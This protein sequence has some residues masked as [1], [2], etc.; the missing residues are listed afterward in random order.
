MSAE[1]INQPPVPERSES[2]KAGFE[3]YLSPYTYRYGS[4]EMKRIWS[5][6]DYWLTSRDIWVAV[7]QIQNKAGLVSDK[8]LEDLK[9]HRYDLSVERILQLEREKGHDVGGAI[10]EF[11]EA[12]PIGG[13]IVH[14]GLTSEDILSNIEIIQIKESFQIIRERLISTLDAFG[15][16]INENKYLVCMGW[17]H[18]Q[19]AEPT[20]Y[21]YRFAKYA[22]DLLSDLKLLDLANPM[23]K[24]KGIKGAVGTS[25]SFEELLKDTQMSADKHEEM[26]MGKLDIEAASIT[27]QTYPRKNLF[28]TETILASIGQSLH[29]FAFDIQLLQSSAIDEVSE[30]R[31][32]GQIGSSAMPHKQN[33]I[34][35]ENI[36]SIT[37]ELPGKLTSSWI[38][39]AFVSLERTLRD[40]AGKRSYLPESF[41]IVDEALMRT[42]KVISGLEIHKS[43]VK[44]NLKKFAPFCA[45][46]I[47]LAKLSKAGMD[48]KEAHEILREHSE[49]A[50]EA[51]RSRNA[52]PFEQL[53]LQDNRIKLLV[54]EKELAQAFD[55]V[56]THVGNASEK[57][58][59]F[60]D[61]E[62]YPAIR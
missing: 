12:A 46:E 23:I 17:T 2:Y 38:T 16:R 48:R 29:R 9:Q 49:K 45:S 27:D 51:R 8:Q 53:V 10:A 4:S 31:K 1:N 55:D 6:Q 52:N 36:D 58:I 43:S 54:D 34:N 21:G 26:I 15:E 39:G 47:I 37:E 19:A 35:C 11:S 3:T 7:A 60:L 44:S 32:K 61:K 59:E 25:A 56:F 30:P 50:V 57:C 28:L 18:L 14:Q 22:A 24:A 40:S 42:E 41:L 13:E 20:T 5:Q 33:P 62:L